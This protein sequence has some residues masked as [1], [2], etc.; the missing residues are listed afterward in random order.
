MEGDM[1]VASDD[2]EVVMYKI[3]RYLYE[4][5]KKDVEPD[6]Q[7]YG[8]HSQLLNVPQQYWCKIIRILVEKNLIIGFVILSTKDGVQIQTKP[9]IE[10]T[11]EGREFLR[12]NS[13]MQKAKDVCGETFEVLLS[14]ALGIIV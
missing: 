3:L 11:Y 2:M 7:K 1:N 13:G 10:I 5:M 4:C 14:A 6:L 8:W 9:P 12:E